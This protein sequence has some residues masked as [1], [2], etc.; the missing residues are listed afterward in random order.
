MH[1][2]LLNND[3]L[4]IIYSFVGPKCLYINPGFFKYYQIMKSEFIEKPIK[5]KYQLIRWKN[6]FYN[7]YQGRPSMLIEDF[8]NIEIKG[9]LFR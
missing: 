7:N 6:K 4:T 9:C 8:Q 2:S 5:L 3:L 1:I